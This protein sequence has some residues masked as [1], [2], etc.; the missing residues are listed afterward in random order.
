MAFGRIIPFCLLL[1]RILEV[2]SEFVVSRP[3]SA[4]QRFPRATLKK[5]SSTPLL[6]MPPKS[7][8]K[9]QSCNVAIRNYGPLD[10]SQGL[11]L[12]F[13]LSNQYKTDLW[14][15]DFVEQV[16]FSFSSFSFFCF[17]FNFRWYLLNVLTLITENGGR[18]IIR[19][20]F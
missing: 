15:L 11:D 3:R 1:G 19:L 2:H 9:I 17:L 8:T 7:S 5:Q 14:V 4:R 20:P 6:K 13:S 16:F 12:C 18:K 10:H